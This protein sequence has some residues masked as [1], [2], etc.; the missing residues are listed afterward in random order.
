MPTVYTIDLIVSIYIYSLCMW[1]PA[2]LVTK[3]SP[4]LII[5]S[6]PV[7]PQ[8]FLTETTFYLEAHYFSTNHQR[9]SLP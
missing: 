3:G 5:Y 1:S 9:L 2:L 7:M 6:G 8:S 4:G